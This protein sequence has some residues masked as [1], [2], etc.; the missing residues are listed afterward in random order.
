MQLLNNQRRALAEEA[1]QRETSLSAQIA[2]LATQA[3]AQQTE[4]QGPLAEVERLRA[5]TGAQQTEGQGLLGEVQERKKKCDVPGCLKPGHT[6][7]TC[8]VKNPDPRAK[9]V[10]AGAG[11]RPRRA[12]PAVEAPQERLA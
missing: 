9:A 3:T 5:A 1:A 10:A 7:R 8:F 2:L 11:P 6:A 4:G 12:A